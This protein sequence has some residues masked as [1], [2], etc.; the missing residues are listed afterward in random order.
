MHLF[1]LC[2]ILPVINKYFLSTDL[3]TA[4][5][6]QIFCIFIYKLHS[7]F[8]IPGRYR[9]ALN[10]TFACCIFLNYAS[11]KSHEEVE[12]DCYGLLSINVDCRRIPLS[13]IIEGKHGNFIDQCI[14][15]CMWVFI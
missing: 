15:K 10:F 11:L 5:L 3:K 14:H 9:Q 12:A 2:Q 8:Y 4:I 13:I 7:K 6:T 1:V